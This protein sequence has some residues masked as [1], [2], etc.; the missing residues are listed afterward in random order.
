MTPE[1]LQYLRTTCSY[2]D[3]QDYLNFLQEFRFRPKEHVKLDFLTSPNDDQVG[4]L[5]I[6][7]QGRWVETILYE[8]PLLALVSKAYFKFCD[9]DW[10]YEGQ[11]EKACAKGMR[12]IDAG[13]VFTDFGARR[14]RDYT[15]QDLIIQGLSDAAEQAKKTSFSEGRFAG[16]S[17]VHFAMKHKVPPMG[18]VAH[19][20]FMGI[21]AATADYFRATDRALQYWL[22]CYGVGTLGIALTDTFGTPEFL[23]AFSLPVAKS[24]RAAVEGWLGSEVR[25]YA[26]LYTG[27]RQDSGDPE[28]FLNIMTEYYGKMELDNKSIVFSDSLNVDKCIKYKDLAEERRFRPS[29]GI[30]THLTSGFSLVSISSIG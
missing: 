7:I 25:P 9:A 13:C 17:N 5:R 10:S 20:W 18:T 4:D 22:Q 1:E 29:F 23:K 30:G 21:A 8:T 19:E 15:T 2:L 28:D 16:T 14:R 26:A 11:R 27:V 24:E 3:R 6:D 12:L